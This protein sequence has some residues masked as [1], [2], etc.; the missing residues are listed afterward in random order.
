ME[1]E[2]EE[3]GL[4]GESGCCD[5]LLVSVGVV[6]GWVAESSPPLALLLSVV[7]IVL[8]DGNDC[9]FCCG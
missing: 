2:G 4:L 7:V 5:A 6:D 3:D 8:D 9:L 1:E